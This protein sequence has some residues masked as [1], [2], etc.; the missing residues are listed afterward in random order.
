MSS[1]YKITNIITNKNYIGY[2]SRSIARRFYEHKWEALNRE[3]SCNNSYLYASMRKYGTDCF[4]IEE[5]F[6]FKEDE[7]NWKELEQYYI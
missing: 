7:Y 5:L 2:T 3:Y 6:N 4:I 1:I